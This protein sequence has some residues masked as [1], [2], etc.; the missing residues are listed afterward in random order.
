[1]VVVWLLNEMAIELLDI[2]KEGSQH[3][4]IGK[5]DNTEYFKAKTK[6]YP[7]VFMATE[8]G[9]PRH[10]LFLNLGTLCAQDHECNAVTT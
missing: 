6:Q 4:Y 1:M 7:A 3:F 8:P 9:T 10:D 5:H 2:L